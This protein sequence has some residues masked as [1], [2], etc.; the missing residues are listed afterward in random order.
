MVVELP[1]Q[2]GALEGL[3]PPDPDAW[4]GN[5]LR[6]NK[7]VEMRRTSEKKPGRFPFGDLRVPIILVGERTILIANGIE[8]KIRLLELAEE[9]A[10]ILL[11]AWP[12]RMS[13]DIFLLDNRQY[14]LG[15]LKKV[16]LTLPWPTQRRKT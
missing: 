7:L 6:G 12:G 1:R 3:L 5:Y 8:D 2:A 15:Y 10:C 4:I 9:N 14:A 11:A 13:Q 16:S